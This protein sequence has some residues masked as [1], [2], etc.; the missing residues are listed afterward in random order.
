MLKKIA[1]MD[2]GPVVRIQDHQ[3]T[4]NLLIW[5]QRPRDRLGRQMCVQ[6]T[7]ITMPIGI[8]SGAS[9]GI[10]SSMSSAAFALDPAHI[11]PASNRGQIGPPQVSLP[12]SKISPSEHILRIVD[13]PKPRHP[14]STWPAETR[15][16]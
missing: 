6:A 5:T 12:C 16:A 13:P 10:R 2:L 3:R 15:T 1:E 11:P 9:R 14:G 4:M 8:A 7:L